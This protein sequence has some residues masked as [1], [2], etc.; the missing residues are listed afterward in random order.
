MPVADAK[1]RWRQDLGGHERPREHLVIVEHRRTIKGDV[2]RGDGTKDLVA[3]GCLKVELLDEGLYPPTKTIGDQHQCAASPV[4]G[5]APPLRSVQT[6]QRGG[7]GL[8]GRRRPPFDAGEFHLHF[9][10]GDQREADAALRDSSA[11]VNL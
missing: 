6:L 1:R 9:I 7:D 8:R 3:H 11:R 2:V 5:V 10:G 4:E